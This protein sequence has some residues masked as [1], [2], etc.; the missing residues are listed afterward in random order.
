MNNPY[1][2]QHQEMG[3]AIHRLMSPAT[4]P[5]ERIAGAV[6]A[7]YNAFAHERTPSSG[8]CRSGRI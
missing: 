3:E 6:V 4:P 2:Y 5:E 8:P 1:T 7:F